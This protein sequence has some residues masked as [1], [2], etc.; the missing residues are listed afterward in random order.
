MASEGRTKLVCCSSGTWTRKR[1]ANRASSR[2]VSAPIVRAVRNSCSSSN[3]QMVQL[4]RDEFASA[5]HPVKEL[6]LFSIAQLFLAPGEDEVVEF[7]GVTRG[8]DQLDGEPDAF[9]GVPRGGFEE[10]VK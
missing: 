2:R 3:L 7:S 10:F 1:A 9:V 5:L 4:E 6:E 8:L